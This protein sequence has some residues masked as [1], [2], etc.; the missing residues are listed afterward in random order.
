[1]YPKS[2]GSLWRADG[3]GK[4][5]ISLAGPTE[6]DVVLPW[7]AA[8]DGRTIA[9]VSGVGV[10]PYS[11]RYN[12]TPALALWLVGADGT[13]PRK[14]QDLLPPRG[15]DLTPG[16]DDAFNLLPALAGQ[17]ELAW[18]PDGGLVAF[19]SAHENQVDL[20]AAALDG[21][22]TRLT[23]T[24]RLEQGPRWSPD[25]G[26]I[27]YRTTSGFGS[28][29]GWGEV[30]LEVT[31]RGGDSIAVMDDRKLASGGEAGAI[32]QF[33]WIGPD[34]LVAGLWDSQVGNNEVR[35]LTVSTGATTAIFAQPYS[36]L[37]WNEATG[38]LVIAGPSESAIEKERKLDPGLYTWSPGAGQATQI[39]REP[40]E[41]IAW[42]PR[43][44]ALAYSVAKGGA[45]P[46]VWIWSIGAE[47]DVKS[48]SPT[49][50]QQLVWSPDGQRLAADA[51]IYG[52]DG[53]KQTGL[54]DQHVML[55]GW[56]GEGLFYL[57]L[58]D[59]GASDALR[60]WDG[61]AVQPVDT[62]VIRSGAAHIVAPR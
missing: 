18:S 37:A 12:N 44:D 58:N 7:A 57:A 56:G 35:A 51:T 42:S 49:P 24:A 43:G 2:D 52:R 46:G 34:T 10:W 29:A 30:A 39:E 62:E 25:G 45:R 15:V 13:N 27:A 33:F 53:K 28:G 19:V 50:T 31:S 47:G 54:A 4:R 60:L 20:Y 8:P 40:V 61:T 6:A 59:S 36:A 3:A 5:P 11:Y 48:V 21:M 22:V 9:L 23:N 38:Q 1:V 17:Q 55:L 26:A 41:A 32:P 16:G 14:V